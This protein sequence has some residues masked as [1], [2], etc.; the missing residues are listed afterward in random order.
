VSRRGNPAGFVWEPGSAKEDDS[1][2]R[3]DFFP[4]QTANN[5][6]WGNVVGFSFGVEP[7]CGNAVKQDDLAPVLHEKT[8]LAIA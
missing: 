4:H 7:A 5:F 6:R 2:G 8:A 1:D 3:G